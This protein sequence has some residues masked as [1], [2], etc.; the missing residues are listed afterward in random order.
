MPIAGALPR[1]I[2]L[3][4]FTHT[5]KLTDLVLL[6]GQQR[7][8]GVDELQVGGGCD[9]D[10]PPVLGQEALAQLL[11]AFM[12]QNAQ[13]WHLSADLQHCSAGLRPLYTPLP[14]QTKHS[15]L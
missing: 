2:K 12:E 7:L 6:F 8:V 15:Q 3:A 14:C 11:Y 1:S 4:I 10:M 5:Q 13:L 9:V